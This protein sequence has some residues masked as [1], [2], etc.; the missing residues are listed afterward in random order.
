MQ[1][2]YELLTKDDHICGVSY[3]FVCMVHI[4]QVHDSFAGSGDIHMTKLHYIL[5]HRTPLNGDMGHWKRRSSHTCSVCPRDTCK[6][7]RNRRRHG[8]HVEAWDVRT[9]RAVE[10]RGNDM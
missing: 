6:V 3:M 5:G 7:G 4:D 10:C 2:S 9:K 1:K 8:N